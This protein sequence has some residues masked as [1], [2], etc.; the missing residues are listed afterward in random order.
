MEDLE[1]GFGRQGGDF[2][3]LHGCFIYGALRDLMSSVGRPHG[4]STSHGR[5]RVRVRVRVMSRLEKT[6]HTHTHTS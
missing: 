2:A 4:Y 6:S 5:V 1:S 3:V